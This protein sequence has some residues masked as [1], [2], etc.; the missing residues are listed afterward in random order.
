MQL[1]RIVNEF[2][3]TD[4]T[5]YAFTYTDTASFE[6]E[7]DEWFSYNDA[8]YLRLNRARKT[9]ERRWKKCSA[10][11]WL[12]ADDTER[13]MFVGQEVE[14]LKATDL[15]TRVKSLQTILHVI[16]GVWDES[17]GGKARA[18]S[19]ET[20]KPKTKATPGQVENIKAGIT[21]V[22]NAGGISILFDVL[23]NAFKKLWS[24]FQLRVLGNA[25]E[26]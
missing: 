16:L 24:D 2:P 1:R 15:R 6:E 9:F 8:E 19:T 14:G 4:P 25:H 5:A 12:E 11:S 17:A 3:K 10:S 20:P 26:I 23:Q 18:E 13:K 7:V 22:A 21:L